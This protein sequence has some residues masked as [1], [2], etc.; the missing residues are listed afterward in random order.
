MFENFDPNATGGAGAGGQSG[1]DLI[2][3]VKPAATDN[4]VATLTGYITSH[5]F[6]GWQHTF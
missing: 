6:W 2:L 4:A 5:G 3:F 1:F